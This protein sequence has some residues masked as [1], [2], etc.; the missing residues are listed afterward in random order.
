MSSDTSNLMAAGTCLKDLKSSTDIV[1]TKLLT[2]GISRGGPLPMPNLT[3]GSLFV[4]KERGISLKTLKRQ[5]K[6][7]S[8]GLITCWRQNLR[9]PPTNDVRTLG[10]KRELSDLKILNKQN[11]KKKKKKTHTHTHTQR[12]RRRCKLVLKKKVTEKLKVVKGSP[13]IPFKKQ[14]TEAQEK[15]ICN[16]SRVLQ[17]HKKG[18]PWS[19]S[20][21]YKA[22][23]LTGALNVPLGHHA[24]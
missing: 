22:K 16:R 5:K 19:P 4:T 1:A 24:P 17:N 6:S 7:P 13:I 14:F 9:I 21:I 23:T 3:C 12:R 15:A 8:R 18:Q 11:H 20:P 2:L 10:K